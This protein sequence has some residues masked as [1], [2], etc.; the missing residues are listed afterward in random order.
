MKSKAACL[1]VAFTLIAAQPT[2]AAVSL[3]D[4]I[5]AGDRASAMKQIARKADVNQPSAEDGSTPLLWAVHTSDAEL[6]KTL[7]RAGADV[8]AANA[9]G[10]TPMREAATNGNVEILKALLDAGADVESPAPQ[11]Q[12]SLMVVAR[13]ANVEAAALLLDRGANV[14]AVETDEQQSALMWAL[15]RRQ[16]E[17]VR[18]LVSRGADVHARSREYDQDILLTAE[19]RV[20]YN[21]TGGMTPL[22][23]AAREGCI[24]CAKVLIGAGAK[25]NAA[26]PDGRTPLLVALWNAHFDLADYLMQ[27][28]ADVNR[29]DFWG[30]TPLW[31]AVDYHTIPAGGRSDLP[32]LDETAPLELIK[33]LLAAGANPNA[34]LKFFPPIRQSI[35]DRGADLM[36]NTGAT[37]LLRAARAGDTEVVELLLKAGARHDLAVAK[38]WRLTQAGG[39]ALVAP[40]EGLTPVMAAAGL[41]NQVQDTRGKYKTQA[42]AIATIKALAAAGADVNARTGQGNTALL[43]AVLRGWNDVVRTL[44]ELGA[45]PYL[46]NNDGKS[47]A[48]VAA[49]SWPDSRV[50]IVDINP[51]TAKLIAQLKPRAASAATSVAK[52]PVAQVTTTR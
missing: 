7:L 50:Q 25:V 34:Q 14:N 38:P 45:D 49:S 5:K 47:P 21:P 12:T 3:V 39:T 48:D 1:V 44:I 11:G 37:P 29:W 19:P 32:S 23:F 9:F 24:E 33:R 18:L 28:G 43:G 30:R 52:G 46:P 26:D 20:L 16:P 36:F 41:S 40:I 35:A 31:M 15:A 17:M 51:E 13:T 10:L 2:W 6:V 8:K 42:Q 4:S 27:V 22:L